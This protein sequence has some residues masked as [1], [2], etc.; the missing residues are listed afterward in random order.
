MKQKI[1]KKGQ[2]GHSNKDG[3]LKTRIK[4]NAL[5]LLFEPVEIPTTPKPSVS[6]IG[7]FVKPEPVPVLEGR[8]DYLAM[9]NKIK[10]LK[11][12]HPTALYL[13]IEGI[14][15][16]SKIKSTIS[17]IKHFIDTNIFSP[18]GVEFSED[19]ERI[20]VLCDINYGGDSIRHA[21]KYNEPK[22]KQI[23]T[24]NG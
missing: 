20:R 16:D 9:F 1:Q 10:N 6:F 2:T 24:A 8:F 11:F 15:N 18:H 22:R 13:L 5:P 3:R 21:W 17:I 23:L 14:G 4:E 7:H 19:Y 12:S